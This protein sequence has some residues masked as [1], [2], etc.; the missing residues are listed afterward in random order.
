MPGNREAR[1]SQPVDQN[2]MSN[3]NAGP[4]V[5]PPPRPRSPGAR[6]EDWI[7]N[8]LRHVYDEALNEAIP[9]SMLDLLDALDEG[10]PQPKPD[11]EDASR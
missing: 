7:A 3:A 2:V 4:P 10:K 5:A 1:K 9:Q 11:P 8:Q 6:K